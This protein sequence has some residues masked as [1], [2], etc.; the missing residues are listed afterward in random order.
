MAIRAVRYTVRNADELGGVGIFV[1]VLAQ[2][3]CRAEI[4]VSQCHFHV[5]WTMTPRA[6][7]RAMRTGQ[8]I[9]SVIVIKSDQVLP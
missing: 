3:W 2:F 1:A 7:R 5:R 4:Y 9:L 8:R 6:W